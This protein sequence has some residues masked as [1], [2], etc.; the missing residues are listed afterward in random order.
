MELSLPTTS[1]AEM[2]ELT[3]LSWRAMLGAGKDK[4][5]NN[6]LSRA[7]REVYNRQKKARWWLWRSQ[8]EPVLLLLIS[9]G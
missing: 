5:P 7:V 4:S 1:P 6:P 8:R 9:A 2:R 3:P